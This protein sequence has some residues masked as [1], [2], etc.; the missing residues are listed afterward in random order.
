MYLQERSLQ[1]VLVLMI[2]IAA[3]LLTGCDQSPATRSAQGKTSPLEMQGMLPNLK[4]VDIVSCNFAVARSSLPSQLSVP[5][6][7]RMQVTGSA[8]VSDA[9]AWVLKTEPDWNPIS[10]QDIPKS[11]Q[12]ILPS[13]DIIVSSKLN[14]SF[15]QNPTY[16]HGFVVVLVADT[17]RIMYFFA[18]DVDHPNGQE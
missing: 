16:A 9:G 12:A 5:S 17:G 14:A 1:L 15:D 11:L 2:A 10:R 6:D 8:A 7:T 3:S 18:T 4:P 13:R